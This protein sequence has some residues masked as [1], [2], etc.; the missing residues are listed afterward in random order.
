MIDTSKLKVGDVVHVRPRAL[1]VKFLSL[2]GAPTMFRGVTGDSW[3]DYE[4]A[5][6][7][8]IEPRPL[9]VGDKVTWGTKDVAYN[10]L[11]IRRG[12]AALE[13]AFSSV[14]DYPFD[15]RLLSDL[16]RVDD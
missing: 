7:V 8:H 15:I 12:Y 3:S 6:I 5:D 2:S 9:Q 16:A 14:R 4:R 11:S 10:I 1:T 13:M